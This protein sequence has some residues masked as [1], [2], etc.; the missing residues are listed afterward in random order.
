MQNLEDLGLLTTRLCLPNI[1]SSSVFE[2]LQT[3]IAYIWRTDRDIDK[4]KM[5]VTTLIDYMSNAAKMVN[6]GLQTM[7]FCCLI[8]NHPSLTLRLIYMYMIMQL[9]SGH[10]TLLCPK[11]QLLNCPRIGLMAP[12]GLTLGSASYF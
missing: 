9:R 12:G 6:L 7:K 11:F 1:D 8:S 4:R 5:V 2:K 3:L 10:V